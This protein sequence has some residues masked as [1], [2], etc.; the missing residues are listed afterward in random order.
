MGRETPLFYRLTSEDS[1]LPTRTG[2]TTD[3]LRWILVA[4]AMLAGLLGVVTIWVSVA[5]LTDTACG[6][7]ALVAALDFALLLRLVR[8]PAGAARTLVA[9]AMTTLAIVLSAWL[10]VAAQMGTM[11]GL[12]P[13]RSAVRLGPV[14]ALEY[15]RLGFHGWD[16]ACVAFAPLLAGLVAMQARRA[17]PARRDAA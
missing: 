12:D 10:V 1:V 16:W 3:H 4:A 15:T 13:L 14:L 17:A 8:A 7:M 11:L 2:Q 9:I 5:L 6:W